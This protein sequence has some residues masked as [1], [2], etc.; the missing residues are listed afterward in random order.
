VKAYC[1]FIEAN[2]G[3]CV[4]H[5]KSI[6]KESNCAFWN[7]KQRTQKFLLNTE[8]VLQQLENCLFNIATLKKIINERND[9]NI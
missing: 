6:N 3:Y 4:R 9:E 8:N 1:E 5:N 7:K 2:K